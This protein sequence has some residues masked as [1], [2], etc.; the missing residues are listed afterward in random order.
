MKLRAPLLVF[1]FLVVLLSLPAQA[2][3]DPTGGLLFQ[4]LMPTL[5][6]IWGT[7]MIFARRIRQ[8]VTSVL[9][10]LRGMESEDPAA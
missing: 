8:L 10:K 6:A 7:W 2:Y 9:R 1:L 5:A 4:I 3:A